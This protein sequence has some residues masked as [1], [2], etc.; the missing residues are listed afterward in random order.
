M[1]SSWK[2]FVST[3]TVAASYAPVEEY[4]VT[5]PAD[6]SSAT[7]S[8]RGSTAAAI[9]HSAR[10]SARD[11][12]W[13]KT[14][15]VVVVVLQRQD[16]AW[17]SQPRQPFAA[18]GNSPRAHGT[19]KTWPESSSSVAA[20]GERDDVVWWTRLTKPSSRTWTRSA[21]LSDVHEPPLP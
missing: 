17:T 11:G 5:P 18:V 13:S 2:S 10:M 16:D 14:R 20:D 21:Q 15:S 1:T 7:P 3:K 8:L 19:L 6:A 12:I 9:L 4:A